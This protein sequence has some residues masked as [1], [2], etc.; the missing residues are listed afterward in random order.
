MGTDEVKLKAYTID[1]MGKETLL[2]ATGFNDAILRYF[3]GIPNLRDWVETNKLGGA[4]RVKRDGQD[5]E[6]NTIPI[7][8]NLRVISKE[9][10]VEYLKNNTNLDEAFIQSFI[11]SQIE[12]YK[13]VI[14]K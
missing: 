14:K 2:L 11:D 4:I 1:T 12:K 3:R 5:H 6:V 10:G 9:E 8:I 13:W 7:L